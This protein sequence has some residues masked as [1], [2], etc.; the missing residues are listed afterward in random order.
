MSARSSSLLAEA[1][2]T[3]TLALPLVVTQ[4]SAV[5]MNFVDT[6][7]AGHLG[8]NVLAAVAVGTAVWSLVFV[9]CI[10]IM[11][12]VPPSVS[13]LHGA[14]RDAEIGPLFR[15][16][17]WL[18]LCAGLLM[19]LAVRG[20]GPLL[21][22]MKV[23]PAI[24]PEA[25]GFLHGISWGAPALTLFFAFRGLSEGLG[26]AR[27]AMYFGFL[28]LA[29]LVPVGYLL[30]YGGLGIPGM[31]ALGCGYATAIVIWVQSLGM[32]RYL[33]AR[34][35][36]RHL[37][38]FSRFDWPHWPPIRD[39]LR[40][41]VPMAITLFMEG[42]LF[43]CVALLIGS[44]GEATVA[45]H[46]IAINVASIT[47][48][49]PLGIAMAATVRVG[50]AVG[51]GDPQGVRDACKVA[52]ILTLA[53]QCVSAGLMLGIPGLIAGLYTRDTAIVELAATLL[54]YAGVFQ[55]SDGIQVVANGALRGLK[56]TF[57]PMLLTL[58]AYWAIGMSFGA[59]LAF[60]LDW[61]A[62]GMWTGLI[63]GLTAA[64]FGLLGRL[65]LR[66]RARPA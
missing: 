46:Q 18:A 42:S 57:V 38:L 52:L 8:S 16:V 21:A 11:L 1:R 63:A 13:Q 15:Q 5:G 12:A 17:L 58:I 33:S 55:F 19:M 59:W 31:G 65:W 43:V 20:A 14:A 41:G 28:G 47:F 45:G 49:V 25:L 7:L 29:L 9:L 23:D 62:E 44:L 22:A 3:V 35:H 6:V 4:L 10:G 34:R 61:G 32:A 36:Y 56:D 27:P 48:M 40:V 54:F 39:L 51:R 53:T 64:A 24:V 30:M 26:L 2:A 37:Q 66:V 60:G 50:H